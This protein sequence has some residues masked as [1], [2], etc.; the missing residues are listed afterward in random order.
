MQKYTDKEYSNLPHVIMSSDKVWNPRVFDNII[1]RR[2][3][4]F[5]Q[6]VNKTMDPTDTPPQLWF[7]C[8]SYVAYILNLVSDP[9][10][11]DQQPILRATG[12]VGDISPIFS[13]EW[14]EP[15]YFKA[16]DSSFPKDSPEK[17]GYFVAFSENVGHSMTYKIWNKE[18]NKIIDRSVVR[19]AESGS[20]NKK[21]LNN[22]QTETFQSNENMK[23]ASKPIFNK[24]IGNQPHS[25][26][27]E[28]SYFEDK[29]RSPT[30]PAMD[31]PNFDISD[32][33]IFRTPEGNYQALKLDEHDI[34]LRDSRGNYK[35]IPGIDPSNMQGRTFSKP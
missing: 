14:L 22:I 33:P 17:F 6:I 24:L 18:T 26:H 27:G 7:L 12:Q 34:P 35:Y 15:V 19:S 20:A 21:A 4:T 32:I 30:A 16:N 10:L 8:M 13:F 2:Y 31:A 11:G 23:T 5:K 3:Q 1:E 25:T 29:V 28:P 9:T